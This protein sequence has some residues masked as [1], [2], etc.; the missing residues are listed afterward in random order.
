MIDWVSQGAIWR[1][2][3]GRSA[4]AG[5]SAVSSWSVSPSIAP[6]VPPT[7]TASASRARRIGSRRGRSWAWATISRASALST[8]CSRIPPR[9]ARL[10]GT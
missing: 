6:T 7:T 8:T 5:I 2:S 4:S 10:I 1:A 3:G 9:Y